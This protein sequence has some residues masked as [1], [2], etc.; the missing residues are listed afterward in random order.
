[1]DGVGRPHDSAAGSHR[2]PTVEIRAARRCGAD[3]DPI[4]ARHG[5]PGIVGQGRTREEGLQRGASTEEPTQTQGAL[6]EGHREGQGRR[7]GPGQSHGQGPATLG[8][9]AG[10][11]EVRVVAEE[12][13]PARHT[14]RSG[15]ALGSALALMLA[16]SA[17]AQSDDVAGTHQE[18]VEQ[19]QGAMIVQGRAAGTYGPDEIRSPTAVG[20]PWTSRVRQRRSLRGSPPALHR[21]HRAQLVRR[22]ADR[23]SGTGLHRRP[24][25]E[26]AHGRM[27]SPA[28]SRVR[29]HPL[30]PSRASSACPRRFSCHQR[31]HRSSIVRQQWSHRE[32][33]ESASR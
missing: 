30:I 32:S 18:N 24:T 7:E 17:T 8:A 2:G 5:N 9:R 19:L 33:G 20:S 13:R 31:G 23:R 12:G 14:A 1:V 4:G 10:D 22:R 29:R 3:P 27:P 21:H 28:R 11:A 15:L 6:G 26:L 16:A 25:R